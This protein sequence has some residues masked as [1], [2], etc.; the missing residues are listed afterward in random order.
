MVDPIVGGLVFAA[1]LGGATKTGRKAAGHTGRTL[2][3]A[4]KNAT[5]SGY[6]ATGW[7]IPAGRAGTRPR[8]GRD[9]PPVG[10]R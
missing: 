10:R 4:A 3:R 6:T 8:G 9:P 5:T 2:G 1:I 7:R